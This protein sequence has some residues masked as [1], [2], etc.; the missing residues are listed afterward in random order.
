MMPHLA[1]SLQ[2]QKYYFLFSCWTQMNYEP[3]QGHKQEN[4]YIQIN[5]RHC[6][7]AS[8][9][10]KVSKVRNY[11]VCFFINLCKCTLC[12]FIVM[13]GLMQQVPLKGLCNSS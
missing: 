4:T 11:L 6:L 13:S 3:L 1:T 2:V 7:F 8:M 5:T 12:D 9:Y 10:S